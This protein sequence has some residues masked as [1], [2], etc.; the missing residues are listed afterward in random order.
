MAKVGSV[1]CVSFLVEGI[2][3]CDLVVVAGSFFF[4]VG[5][6]ASGCVFWGVCD[7]IMILGNLSANGWCCFPVLLVVCHRLSSTVA[8]WLLHGDGSWY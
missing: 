7:L 6:S 3:A 5:R 4:L 8:C 1:G 2:S